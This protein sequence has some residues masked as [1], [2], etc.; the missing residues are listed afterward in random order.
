MKVPHANL[1]KG[2]MRVKGILMKEV[3][4]MVHL[5]GAEAHNAL[6]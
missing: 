1:V 4:S 6:F 2:K 3:I 5:T